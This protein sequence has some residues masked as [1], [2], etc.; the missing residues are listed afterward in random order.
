MPSDPRIT[1]AS[2]SPAKIPV[3]GDTLVI[4][5]WAID[6]HWVTGTH[7]SETASRTGD[8]HLR[9]LHGVYSAVVSLGGVGHTAMLLHTARRHAGTGD[10]PFNIVGVGLWNGFD[11]DVLRSMFNPEYLEQFTP[12]R[13]S[14]SQ[15]KR[16]RIMSSADPRLPSLVNIAQVLQDSDAV[17]RVLKEYE[18]NGSP[19]DKNKELTIP[20]FDWHGTNRVIRV[21][22]EAGRDLRQQGRV[23]WQL[24]VP[25]MG[26]SHRPTEWVTQQSTAGKLKEH[27]KK[28]ID[29]AMIQRVVVGDL[30]KGVISPLVVKTLKGLVR[31]EC[32]WFVST[33]NWKPDWFKELR[34]V[35]T[36]L[37]VL[38]EGAARGAMRNHA[39]DQWITRGANLTADGMQFLDQIYAETHAE[40]IVAM[41]EMWQ[42][43]AR[44]EA[45]LDGAGDPLPSGARRTLAYVQT[46]AEPGGITRDA[47]TAVP[48]LAALVAN[49]AEHWSDN[50]LKTA[51]RAACRR[52]ADDL[53]RLREPRTW[54]PPVE[55]VVDAP[56]DLDAE[57]AELDWAEHRKQ[58]SESQAGVCSI[59]DQQGEKRI[60]LWRAMTT[61]D[62]YV[63]LVPARKHAVQRVLRH[64]RDFSRRPRHERKP[65]SLL[66][67]SAPGSGK[68]FLAQCLAEAMKMTFLEFDISQMV[69]RTDILDCFDTIVTR[70]ATAGRNAKDIMVFV[71]EINARVEGQPVYS[72]FLGP[73]ESGRFVRNGKNYSIKPCVWVFAGTK[74]A[75]DSTPHD[76][77]DKGSDFESRLTL[78][79]IDLDVGNDSMQRAENVY[80]GVSLIKATFPDVRQVSEPVL[81]VF[82]DLEPKISLRDMR[83]FV[84]S[85]EHVQYGQVTLQNI[86]KDVLDKLG[87]HVRDEPLDN[88][89]L[90]VR[91]ESAPNDP[92]ERSDA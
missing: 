43:A 15:R 92:R 34:D 85:F 38:H 39:V 45:Q 73:L 10:P 66:F 29:I 8:V 3:T 5:D 83:H 19:K 12:F 60:Q 31:P 65:I 58:W 42:V 1:Y 40:M 4:G 2:T 36:R 63:C 53:E 67:R 91:I 9:S 57:W 64:I 30:V 90:F 56:G 51:H 28:Y 79:P 74:S 75:D 76:A 48:F 54:K 23:D 89:P 41:P 88:P 82:R 69:S 46:E 84:E 22:R 24:V 47:P 55:F 62:K 49:A 17:Q 25:H 37:I 27:L 32:Q 86:P 80:L 70:Q 68:T 26:D 77:A 13:L 6:E 16:G 35:R 61:L 44:L 11:S 7:R 18:L 78:E 87:V 52:V 81:E 33:K 72:A 50:A 71:D 20:F 59:A 14:A 21:Y